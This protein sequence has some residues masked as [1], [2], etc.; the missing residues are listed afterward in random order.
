[1][2]EHVVMI[3]LLLPLSQPTHAQPP[4]T[5]PRRESEQTDSSGGDIWLK[6]REKKS[7]ILG[8]IKISDFFSYIFAQSAYS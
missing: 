6:R 4:P 7:K 5:C 1:M 2:C 8:K 3:F